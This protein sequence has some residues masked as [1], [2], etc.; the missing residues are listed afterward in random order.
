MPT[1]G[2]GGGN[3]RS[4]Q[5]YSRSESRAKSG[6]P[7]NWPLPKRASDMGSPVRGDFHLS[8][9]RDTATTSPT[10]RSHGGQQ[11]GSLSDRPLVHNPTSFTTKK[12][13]ASVT[14]GDEGEKE[15][16][17]EMAVRNVGYGRSETGDARGERA[18]DAVSLDGRSV[19]TADT[20]TS[21][22]PRETRPVDGF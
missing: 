12:Y 6:G 7:N 20:D 9:P 17:I 5:Y 8:Q 13:Y 21:K 14:P 3:S 1:S 10:N 11:W 2:V 4:S 16:D 19:G 22:F 18:Y 15:G